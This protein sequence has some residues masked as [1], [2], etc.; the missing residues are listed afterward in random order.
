MFHAVKFPPTQSPLSA[1]IVQNR[2]VQS[3][4]RL[5]SHGPI[6]YLYWFV[7]CLLRA[8]IL[9]VLTK[10]MCTLY[11]VVRYAFNISTL[12][13]YFLPSSHSLFFRQN[14]C[15]PVY[16]SLCRTIFVARQVLSFRSVPPLCLQIQ[17]KNFI[18]SDQ[19]S[20]SRNTQCSCVMRRTV[21]AALAKK[22]VSMHLRR[23]GDADHDIVLQIH[24]VTRQTAAFF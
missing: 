14:I 13:S 11:A 4:T 23:S 24:H 20:V 17:V 12:G 3:L 10:S 21:V 22:L 6:G 16:V 1:L 15:L 2:G 9:T 7:L 19:F 5:H 8:M 18:S